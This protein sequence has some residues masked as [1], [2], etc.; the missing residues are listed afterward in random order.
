M[1]FNHIHI[2]HLSDAELVLQYKQSGDDAFFVELYQRYTHLVLG[3]CIKYLKSEAAGKDAVMDIFEKLLTDLKKHD[4]QHFKSWLYMVSKN[5]CLMQLRKKGDNFVPIDLIKT[6]SDGFVETSEQMHLNLQS[7]DAE[8]KKLYEALNQLNDEQ[9]IC[10]EMFYL[11][12][13]CYQDIAD[14]TGF[15]LNQVKSYIQNGKRNLKI[16]LEK[17]GAVKSTGLLL[18]LIELLK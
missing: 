5:H 11:N 17:N 4:V 15:T 2:E 7:K 14:T 6:S 3:T 12:N 8:E 13:K 10:V 1:A 18:L 9:K 16:Y